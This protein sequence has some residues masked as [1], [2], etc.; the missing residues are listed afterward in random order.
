MM[1]RKLPAK[2]NDTRNPALSDAFI[3]YDEFDMRDVEGK[4]YSVIGETFEKSHVED[5]K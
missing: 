3:N 2:D 1:K 5:R 4:V